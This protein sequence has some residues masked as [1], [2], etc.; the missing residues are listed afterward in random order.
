M[1]RLRSLDDSAP[2]HDHGRFAQRRQVGARIP[3]D[4]DEI[5]ESANGDAADVVRRIQK[6][7]SSTR[8]RKNCH[9]I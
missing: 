3:R 7:G 9:V 4:V 8:R 2:E 5:G 1:I 6:V